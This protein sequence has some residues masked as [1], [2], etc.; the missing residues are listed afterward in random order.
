MI[1][2]TKVRK[3]ALKSGVRKKKFAAP[4][5]LRLKKKLVGKRKS[6][7]VRFPKSSRLRSKRRAIRQPKRGF[8][9]TTT[10]NKAFDEAYNEGFNIGFAQGY[11]LE[12]ENPAV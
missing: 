5:K 7:V 10:Y 1:K 6:K 9:G 4:S 11:A 2:K 8:A 3:L 12:Q